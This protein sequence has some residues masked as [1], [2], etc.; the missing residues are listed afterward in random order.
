VTLAAVLSWRWN[1]TEGANA[2][3]EV[4]PAFGVMA[5]ALPVITAKSST[6]CLTAL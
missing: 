5:V 4:L 3:F 2:L 1:G 6:A